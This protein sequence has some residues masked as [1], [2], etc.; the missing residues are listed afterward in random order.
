MTASLRLGALFGLPTNQPGAASLLG[1]AARPLAVTLAGTVVRRAIRQLATLLR[2]TSRRADLRQSRR[3]GLRARDHP[4]VRCG[5][6]HGGGPRLLLREPVRP[7]PAFNSICSG[8]LTSA[9]H[10]ARYA[11]LR[12]EDGG[13]GG[14]RPSI[15][16][17][18]RATRTCSGIL[19]RARVGHLLKASHHSMTSGFHYSMRDF[20]LMMSVTIPGD[21]TMSARREDLHRTARRNDH[22]ARAASLPS[23]VCDAADLINWC[24]TIY[25]SAPYQSRSSCQRC[26]TTTGARSATRL[27]T[28]TPSRTP[29]RR[30]CALQGGRART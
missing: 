24:F 9:R 26:T 14:T 23:R 10:C 7:A 3:L 13:P 11:N 29:R 4:A 20:R 8:R 17:G 27:S 5:R 1:V 12:V 18:R 16:G 25:Q 22:H 21:G 6:A 30:G 28:S 15:G 19:A 2:L